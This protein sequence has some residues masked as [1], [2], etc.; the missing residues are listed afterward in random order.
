MVG[1]SFVA[2]SPL[3]AVIVAI[4]SALLLLRSMIASVGFSFLALARISSGVWA[5]L[6]STPT[7]FATARI[8]ER[9]RKSSTAARIV[10]RRSYIALHGGGRAGE[11][12]SACCAPYT[13]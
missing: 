12:L 11:L 8:F 3:S 4:G 1:R 9:N 13:T 2:A 7:C 5:N 6:M 10:T